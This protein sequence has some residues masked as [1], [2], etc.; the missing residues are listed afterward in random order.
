MKKSKKTKYLIDVE[1]SGLIA[2]EAESKEDAIDIAERIG[3][4]DLKDSLLNGKARFVEEL[5]PNKEAEF[6]CFSESD[7]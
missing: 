4:D 5:K 6:K 3:T 7:I 2:V 1:L